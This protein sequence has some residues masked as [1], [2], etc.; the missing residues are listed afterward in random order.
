MIDLLEEAFRIGTSRDSSSK[1]KD[2]RYS[3]KR[4]LSHTHSPSSINS[5]TT[6]TV[7]RFIFLS[8]TCLPVAT[9]LETELALFGDLPTN[10]PNTTNANTN[11][12]NNFNAY[13]DAHKSWIN[14]RN[15]PN[16]G[17]AR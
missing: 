6:A 14:A 5:D 10:T 4:Y 2:S 7:D 15:T 1:I 8:E 11:N 17:Y 12:T 16:N 9:L 13:P 3:T